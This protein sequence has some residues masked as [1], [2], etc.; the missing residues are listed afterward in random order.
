VEDWI[1]L[2][3]GITAEGRPFT[4]PA[5]TEQD[6]AAI[7]LMLAGLRRAT[8]AGGAVGPA[9]RSTTLALAG[10]AEARA[11]RAVLCD[12]RRLRG[13]QDLA[14]VGFFAEKRRDRDPAPLTAADDA[15]IAELPRHPGIL[16]YSSLELA[17]GDWG[18]L[19]LLADEAAREHWRTSAR[20]A[21]AVREL[22][23]AHYA[24]VRLH[25][26][27]LP[28]GLAGGR[29]PELRQTR[30]YDYRAEPVWRAER[31]LG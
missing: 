4:D 1:T 19:I 9:G 13:G 24:V 10:L 7:E 12:P 14:W 2:P 16:S 27:V 8:A 23:P 20:H 5:H 18:N 26:G 30:Y 29:R 28:G 11:H 17:S 15:L 3:P 31:T 21:H 25:R 22:A 6:L